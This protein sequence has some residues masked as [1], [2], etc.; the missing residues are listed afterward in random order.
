MAYTSAITVLRL[1]TFMNPKLIHRSEEKY[2]IE[3]CTGEETQLAGWQGTWVLSPVLSSAASVPLN[4]HT[5]AG[6]QLSPPGSVL[7]ADQETEAAQVLQLAILKK[8]C[9]KIYLKG[10]CEIFLKH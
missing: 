7:E 6:A 9:S 2:F 5:L 8:F 4:V 10:S 3:M 1:K